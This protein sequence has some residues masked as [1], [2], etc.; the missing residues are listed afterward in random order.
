Q[1]TGK[2]M[3]FVAE[4]WRKWWQVSE[5][6]FEFPKEVAEKG[7]TAGLVHDLKYFG[8]EIKSKRLAF[9]LDASLSMRE[10]IDVY[11]DGAKP[12]EDPKTRAKADPGGEEKKGAG[13]E[14]K[15]G[16]PTTKARKIDVLKREMVRLLQQLPKETLLNIITFAGTHRPWQET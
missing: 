15:K 9:L 12:P 1:I 13:G 6:S 11:L 2:N 10:E 4:D 3:G 8:V 16:G 7:V 14:E 5:Q